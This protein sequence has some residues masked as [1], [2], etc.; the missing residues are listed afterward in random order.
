[1]RIQVLGPVRAWRADAELALGPPAQ[2]GLFGLLVLADGQPLSRTQL[3]DALW[4][5]EPPS[6]AA[7]VIQTYVKRLR[8]L[9]EPARPARASSTLLPTVGSGYRL[10]PPGDGVDLVSFRRLVD[11]AAA[12]SA[13]RRRAADLLGRALSLWRG[14]PLADIPTLAGHPTVVALGRERHAALGGYTDA[15]IATGAAT[16]ALP[17]LAQDAADHPLDEAAQTR[18]IRAYHAAGQRDRAFAVYHDTRRRLADELGLDPGPELARAHGA[19]LRVTPPAAKTAGQAEPEEAAASRPSPAPG[20]AA[21]QPTVAGS[22]SGSASV[23][24]PA[25]LPVSVPASGPV[26]V[27]PVSIPAAVPLPVPAQL[28][29]DIL[30]FTGRTAELATLSGLVDAGG[31]AVAIAVV[32]GTAGVGKTALAIHWAHRVRDRFPDGQ[33]YVNLRG[34][35]PTERP[36]T[37]AD[38]LAGFLEALGQPVR[39]LPSDVDARGAL[40]RSLLADRRMLLVLDNARDAEQVQPLLPSAPACHAVITSRSQLQGLIAMTG[41]ST[42][43]LDLLSPEES[44]ELLAGRLS[45]ERVRA[46]G[47]AV[48]DIAERCAHL[49][50][51][52][53]VVAARAALRPRFDLEAI[54]AQLRGPRDRLDVLHGGDT[55]TDLRAVFS[56]SFQALDAPARRLFALLALHQGPDISAPA[57]ASLAGLPRRA[58]ERKL[59]QLSSGHLLTEHAPGRYTFHDLLRAYA[60]ELAGTLDPAER[61][62]AV[63]RLLDHYLHTAYAAAVTLNPSTPVSLELGEPPPGVVVDPPA[64]AGEAHDWLLTEHQVLLQ[65]VQWAGDAGFDAH[66]WQLAWALTVFLDRQ[67]SWPERLA[68]HTAALAA[69]ERLDDTAGQANMH[70]GLANTYARMG[71]I[72]Q[73]HIHLWRALDLLDDL[74][75]R[76]GQANLRLNL[77]FVVRSLGDPQRAV[78]HTET[79]LA[80][81]TDLGNKAGQSRAL[82]EIGWQKAISGDYQAALTHCRRALEVLEEVKDRYGQAGAWDSLGYIHHHSGEHQRAITC[83]RQSLHLLEEINDR[84]HSGEVL[85][86][87]GE[88][89]LAVGDSDAARESWAQALAVLTEIEHPDAGPVREKLAALGPGRMPEPVTRAGSVDA[90]TDPA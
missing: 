9:L 36:V 8:R 66:A 63:H 4:A 21:S 37:P 22:V 90:S 83:Y 3:I 45:P 14:A 70:R 7:N 12:L 18:L 71:R 82:H 51:A 59:A 5:D 86:H 76:T 69:A 54:A 49:P 47:P 75:D 10:L 23:P 73:A 2:R 56:W 84:P 11:A 87:L 89:Q 39:R 26:A 6:G 13:D 38:A 33:L 40:F 53:A 55:A 1:M 79:A 34:F 16:D 64:D 68:V 15:M 19:L 25:S 48:D 78:E 27:V 61:R 31:T 58:A 77:A 35:D 50:L 20:E 32:S 85:M 41:A 52:L 62:A 60:V 30:G 24:V 44:R 88:A 72:E 42:L 29:A 43:S 65:L 74:G 28:P 57:A 46:A 81:Y 67:G 80:L 17:L